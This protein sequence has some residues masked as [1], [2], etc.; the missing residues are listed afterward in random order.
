M[1]DRET[2]VYGNPPA[3][4]ATTPQEQP[5]S[6][7]ATP[8]TPSPEQSSQPPRKSMSL[9]KKIFVIFFGTVCFFG[10]WNSIAER[11]NPPKQPATTTTTT[12]SGTPTGQIKTYTNKKYKYTV[13]YPDNLEMAEETPYSTVFTIKPKPVARLVFPLLYVSVIPDR[14]A[15]PDEVYNFMTAETINKFYALPDN[16]SIQTETGTNAEYWK[17]K[18]LASIPVGGIDGVVIQ[19]EN[20]F[21]GNG[22]VNRRILVKKNG[23]TYLIGS[24]FQ[25]QEEL[26]VFRDFVM[27]FS[28]LP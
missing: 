18:K 5:P 16:E 11:I 14:L 3:Q 2:N 22:A 6:Q 8:Q 24:Y 15:K 10:I 9:I 4:V 12:S 7:P 28:F 19:N 21:E 20:V 25:S 13:K 17:F 27:S 23:M 1:E 26:T